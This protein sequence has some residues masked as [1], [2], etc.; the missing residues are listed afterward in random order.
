[1]L[2]MSDALKGL[3]AYRADLERRIATFQN[4]GAGPHSVTGTSEQN[5]QL[6]SLQRRLNSVLN[7]IDAYSAYGTRWQRSA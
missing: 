3:Y 5:E 6:D 4:L 2:G 7:Q 1:M